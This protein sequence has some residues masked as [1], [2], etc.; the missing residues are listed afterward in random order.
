MFQFP[1]TTE[2]WLSIAEAFNLRWNFRHCLGAI[3]GKHVVMPAPPNSGS[4]YIIVFLGVVDANYKFTYI[5]VGCNGKMPDG[6]VFQNCSLSDGLEGVSLHLP[7]SAPLPNRDMAV[8]YCFVADDAF[9]MKSYLLKPYP[10]RD[11]PAPNRIFNYRLSRAR[12]IVETAFG[13]IANKFR[14]LLKPINLHPIKVTNL[15]L[16]ICALH[17]YL[18]LNALRGNYIH[19]GLVD[20]EDPEMHVIIPGIWR[21]DSISENSFLPLQAGSRRSCTHKNKLEKNL[22]STLCRPMAKLRGSINIYNVHNDTYTKVMFNNKTKSSIHFVF[23]S[24]LPH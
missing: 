16:A 11:Q 23:I 13:I 6:G 2:Q 12:R 24:Y 7:E 22:R 18:S 15:F 14:V 3:D 21:D 9:A 10:L 8:P 19:Q 20:M 5:D 17:N 4:H 1:N